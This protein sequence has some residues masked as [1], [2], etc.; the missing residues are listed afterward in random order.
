[1]AVMSRRVLH[2]RRSYT[3]YTMI[4]KTYSTLFSSLLE[5]LHM[6]PQASS[7]SLSILANLRTQGLSLY[8]E[9]GNYSHYD[10]APA[11]LQ[12]AVRDWHAA[13]SCIF[14][15]SEDLNWFH[16]MVTEVYIYSGMS[17]R[18]HL[19]VILRE[20]NTA[21][22][23]G[24]RQYADLTTEQEQAY[25]EK[26]LQNE[27]SCRDW[28]VDRRNPI[29]VLARQ[30]CRRATYRVD[31]GEDSISSRGRHGPGAVFDGSQGLDKNV[32]APPSTRQLAKA[33][34]YT[35]FFMNDWYAAAHSL[36]RA[37]GN[38]CGSSAGGND[39]AIR[40]FEEARITLVPKDYKGPRG[41]FVSSKEAMFC[42]LGQLDALNEAFER[43]WVSACYTPKSQ[44]PSQLAVATGTLPGAG[45]CVTLDLSDAS[46]RVPLSLAAFLF[47]RADYV[48]LARTRPTYL[49]Y[50]SGARKRMAMFAPMG[51]G[52]TF[53]VLS[54]V[55]ACITVATILHEEGL[56]PGMHISDKEIRRAARKCRIYG[57][58][59]I[60][61]KKHASAVVRN[62]E[63]HNLK[64]NHAKSFLHGNFRE[65]CG[66][67]YFRG[68]DVTPLR[69]PRGLNLE[70]RS[71]E[72]IVKLVAWYNR[73]A[74]RS[75]GFS[76][77]RL[78]YEVLALVEGTYWG[79]RTA[80]TY[81]PDVVPCALYLPPELRGVLKTPKVM[82]EP[83]DS[84]LLLRNLR[85]LGVR[86]IRFNS[87]LQRWEVRTIAPS[88][89][90]YLPIGDPWWDYQH[91][92]RLASRRCETPPGED[93]GT[94]KTVVTGS[95]SGERLYRRYA[96]RI[97]LQERANR[98]AAARTSWVPVL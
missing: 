18:E 93:L 56:R 6:E 60:V 5:D 69:V 91:A 33:Y 80:Y 87:D 70:D 9:L 25:E 21:F 3:S 76:V 27:A 92:M 24:L 39:Y 78:T 72:N 79:R 58:D 46:D 67:E 43:S 31:L 64:V 75:W 40:D 15:P 73:I 97:G 51:D 41:V 44:R 84:T 42:Q 11:A 36:G 81:R 74:T 7:C 14:W 45:A 68:L 62:L 55:C 57:D 34:P 77:R 37:V 83:T 88:A 82:F 47:H 63:A 32:F 96:K 8:D 98:S 49:W 50:P 71:H 85:K 20:L 95:P 38:R 28:R 65:S 17:F 86:A 61:V 66:V 53:A 4:S 23:F 89:E 30:L 35:A 48:A 12:R 94:T 54:L 19:G 59:I 16:H 10:D 22:A 90:S 2:R 26:L 1:M 13:V 52:K 29:S